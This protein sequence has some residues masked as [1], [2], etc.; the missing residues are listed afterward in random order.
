MDHMM[1]EMDG[2]ETTLK[3][4][5]LGYNEPSVA[6]SANAVAGQADIFLDNG[7][8]NFISK[9]IDVRQLN[10]I[11]NKYIRDK[12][13]D[14]VAVN[15]KSAVPATVTEVSPPKLLNKKADGIDIEKGLKKFNLDEEV[16]LKILRSFSASVKDIID[17][18]DEIENIGEQTIDSYRIAV[19][20]V[21]GSGRDIFADD[22]GDLAAK[23]ETAAIE[24]DYRYI[25]EHN[26]AFIKTARQ[27]LYN[28]NDVLAA[29]ELETPKSK[30]DKPDSEVLQRLSDSCATY[31]IDDAENA[32]SQLNE[33][34][35]ESDEDN[36]LVEWLCDKLDMMKFD[37]IVERLKRNG[38]T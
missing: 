37:E 32:M 8:D 34:R 12:Y 33:F 24:R 14:S 19:H 20:S 9:P 23:L 3:L 10:S 35:Y 29:V 27:L 36:E 11:L 13:A 31:D 4:R 1:P 38:D 5:E 2:V 7:F 18:I 15:A 21:K 16:Y 17:S 28:I 22:V 26:S 25:E 6:L 30:R